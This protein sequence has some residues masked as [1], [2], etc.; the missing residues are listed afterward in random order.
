M[1][2]SILHLNMRHLAALLVFAGLSA[3]AARFT[4]PWHRMAAG[5]TTVSG[6]RYRLVGNIGQANAG[7]AGSGS[8]VALFGASPQAA[9]VYQLTAGF[10]AVVLQ[11]SPTAPQ[12][13]FSGGGQA[14]VFAWST[15]G[16]GG[17]LQQSTSLDGDATWTDVDAQVTTNGTV[18]TVQ[19]QIPEGRNVIFYRLRQ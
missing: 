8:N 14:G 19:I 7:T 18:R 5:G 4:I 10:T 2:T 11:Q 12:L 13:T 3:D 9:H 17:T 16:S 1:K 15:T 6:G